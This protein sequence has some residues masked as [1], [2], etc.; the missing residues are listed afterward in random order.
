V[1]DNSTDTEKRRATIG[2]WTIATRFV[3]A[4]VSL[5]AALQRLRG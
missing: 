1:V 4:L 3:T 2:R 5:L